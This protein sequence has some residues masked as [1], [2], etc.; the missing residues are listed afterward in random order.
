MMEKQSRMNFKPIEERENM[1]NR[2]NIVK[3]IIVL[4]VLNIVVLIFKEQLTAFIAKIVS[5]I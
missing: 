1:D 5:L 4:T 3:L 2:N